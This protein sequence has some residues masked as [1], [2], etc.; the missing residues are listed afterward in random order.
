MPKPADIVGIIEPKPTQRKFCPTTF[1]D[2]KRRKREGQFVTD[3]EE[4]Y[5]S[6]FIQARIN[7]SSDE[8]SIVEDAICQVAEQDKRYWLE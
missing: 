1:I 7:G 5:C 6:E 3:S 2:I 4:R 8:R